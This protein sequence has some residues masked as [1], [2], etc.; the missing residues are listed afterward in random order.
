VPEHIETRSYTLAEAF[1]RQIQGS[2]I[3]GSPMYASLLNGLL[4][5]YLA[6]GFSAE[7]LEGVSD[8]PLHDAVP[9]RYL[10]VGHRLALEGRAPDL[11]AIYPSCGGRWDGHDL[12]DA[13]LSTVASHRAEFVRGVQRGVQTNEVGRAPVLASGFALL[14]ER[15][16]AKSLDLLEIGSSAGLLSRWD[17]YFY[18][19]GVTHLGD[20][21]SPL[22]FGPEWWKGPKPA[23][24]VD[25]VVARTRAVDVAPID[26][27][28]EEGRI[29]MLSFVWPDQMDRIERLR[30]A[31]GIAAR[32]PLTVDA[33]DAGEWLGE[34]LRD[35][36]AKG[37]VTVV[38]HSI[39]WQ[40]L[41]RPTKD[42]VRAALAHAGARASA[43]APVAWLRMEPSTPEH[44]ELRLTTW[45]TGEQELL[46]HVGYHGADIRWVASA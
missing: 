20:P 22:Q 3:A 1:E 16:H 10:A 43:D 34:Q 40:Y 28:T 26:I 46:A 19:T 17:R 23:L 12:T 2:L 38:F 4:A 30:A 18:D 36:P 25:V 8:A 27:S 44:A 11:A 39:V 33:A 9:L 41:P 24:D 5:D 42:S 37:S 32:H 31:L 6:G 15:Y 14:S 7:I 45:P 13:F 21:A 35:G 29:T